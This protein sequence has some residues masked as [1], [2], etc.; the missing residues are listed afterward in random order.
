MIETYLTQ[1]KNRKLVKMK[2]KIKKIQIDWKEIKNEC[3]HTSNKEDSNVPATLE[4]IKKVLIS[5]HSPIRLGKI[6]WSW[7]GIKSWV[8]VHF[9]RHWLGWDKWVSTQRTDRTG[10]D[11][12]AARQDTPVDMDIES[13]IQALINVSRYRLCKQASDETREY[14]EDAKI[15]IRNAGEKEVSDVMV[16]N[17]IYRAGCPEFECCGHITD[18]I[19]WTKDNGKEINW[20]NI[21]ARYDLYN[22]WFYETRGLKHE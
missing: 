18:F 14:M 1:I 9:A 5:E 3:R 22:K 21:Q 4:F 13:N 7:D 8:S 17:C 2:T 16:P 19:K 20:L 10:V 11:R 12:D 15:E 6:K